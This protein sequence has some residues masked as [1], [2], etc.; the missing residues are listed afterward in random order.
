[1]LCDFE[2]KFPEMCF[3]DPENLLL[4]LLLYCCQ[5]H[6]LLC[7]CVSTHILSPEQQDGRTA[8]SQGVNTHTKQGRLLKP[9]LFEN[10]QECDGLKREKLQSR[11]EEI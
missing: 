6:V 3:N 2:H 9:R 1:M 4:H 7:S 10:I 5:Q 11:T 8:G